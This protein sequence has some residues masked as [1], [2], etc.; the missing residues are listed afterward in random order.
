MYPLL[1]FAAG[2]GASMLVSSAYYHHNSPFGKLIRKDAEDLFGAKPNLA[3]K[4]SLVPILVTAGTHFGW[5][6]MVDHFLAIDHFRLDS[7]QDLFSFLSRL[8]MVSILMDAQ[9]IA[10]E[11]HYEEKSVKSFLIDK[12]HDLLIVGTICVVMIKLKH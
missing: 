12:F 8:A 5:N 7:P 4:S 6:L 2:T 3:K 1:K 11:V 9:H 10:W